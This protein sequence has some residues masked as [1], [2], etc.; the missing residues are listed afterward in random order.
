MLIPGLFKKFN[1]TYI[2]KI[3][4]FLIFVE[5]LYRELELLLVIRPTQISET[6]MKKRSSHVPDIFLCLNKGLKDDVLEDYGYHSQ[7]AYWLGHGSLNNKSFFGWSGLEDEDPYILQ[8]K[9]MLLSNDSHV[10][11]AQFTSV[12][13]DNITVKDAII[14][15]T[16]QLVTFGKCLK[17][18]KHQSQENIT[19]FYLVLKS[20]LCL[21]GMGCRI[22]LKNSNTKYHLLIPQEMTYI[23]KNMFHMINSLFTFL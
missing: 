19:Y 4:C 9:I 17:L 18:S 13:D 5:W 20:S 23:S 10:A 11:S 12:E 7:A 8:E 15:V 1:A 2:F 22:L 16:P 3:I 21:I 14:E 6:Q